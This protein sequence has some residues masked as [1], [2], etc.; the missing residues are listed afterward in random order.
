MGSAMTFGL[1]GVQRTTVKSNSGPLALKYADEP[2][3]QCAR[4]REF[5]ATCADV[6]EIRTPG[7]RGVSSV[8]GCG[9]RGVGR[10]RGLP[11][12]AEGG[13]PSPLAT[14]VAAAQS[15]SARSNSSS[16]HRWFI[17]S[18]PTSHDFVFRC[19]EASNI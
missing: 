4:L 6:Q 12:A 14:A 17:L 8:G 16:L 15:A 2:P 5:P 3:E 11:G 9:A 18:A 1:S 19:S 10:P 13:V 7:R